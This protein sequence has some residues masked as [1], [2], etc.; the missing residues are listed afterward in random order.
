MSA[1]N[2]LETHHPYALSAKVQSTKQDNIAYGNV[3][4]IPDNERELCET[5]IVKE[6]KSLKDLGYFKMVK[7]P[8]GSNILASTWAF[9]K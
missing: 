5:V 2:T 7:R 6:L 9:K 4:Q 1:D 3:V 8:R